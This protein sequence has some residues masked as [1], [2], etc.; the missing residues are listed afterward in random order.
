MA[1]LH[2]SAV[3]RAPDA[4]GQERLYGLLKQDLATAVDALR[5]DL[6]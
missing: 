3:L 5:I 6:A 1:T 2:P 4:E